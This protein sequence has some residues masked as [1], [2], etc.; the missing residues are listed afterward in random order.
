MKTQALDIAAAQGRRFAD[1]VTLNAVTFYR[2]IKREA[3]TRA[4]RL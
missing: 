4:L 1:T 2:K 3:D